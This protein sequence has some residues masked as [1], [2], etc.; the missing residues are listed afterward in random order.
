MRSRFRLLGVCALIGLMTASG[1]SAAE[2]VDPGRIV[3]SPRDWV[4]RTATIRVRFGK[5]NNVF[6]GWE[7]Q[8]N[9][10]P[11]R[12]IKFIVAPLAEIACYAE[13]TDENE[14]L[15]GGLRPGQEIT[16]TGRIRKEKFEARVKG[17]RTTVKRT[18]KGSEVYAFVVSKIESVGEAPS[19]GP[20][21]MGMRRMMRR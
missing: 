9:L 12:Y 4:N 6:H 14:K 18:V 19:E 10:K 3:A 21:G 5:I 11:S 15:L 13:K 2:E 20:R 8:A 17:E 7:E 16:L 1:A